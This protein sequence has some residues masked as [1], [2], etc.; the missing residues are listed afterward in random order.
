MTTSVIS[1]NKTDFN[2]LVTKYPILIFILL[3]YAL[4]WP[5]FIMEVLASYDMLSFEHLHER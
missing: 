2:S 3:V 4:T 5:F 1:T